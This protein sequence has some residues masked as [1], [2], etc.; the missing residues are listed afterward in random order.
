M[1]CHFR[2]YRATGRYSKPRMVPGDF[3]WRR[4][5]QDMQGA[6][7]SKV[8]RRIEC[9]QLHSQH[10][11]GNRRVLTQGSYPNLISGLWQ[12]WPSAD[13]PLRYNDLRFQRRDGA[14]D[15]E[16]YQQT[17]KIISPRYQKIQ[18]GW[19]SHLAR[20]LSL[21]IIPGKMQFRSIVLWYYLQYQRRSVHQ[22]E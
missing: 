9:E 19:S 16:K 5:I 6:D 12:G 4:I 10:K 14:L 21:Q 7:R 13:I 17:G 2:F 20:G 8:Q 3:K 18:T 15:K 11:L 1:E 22:I